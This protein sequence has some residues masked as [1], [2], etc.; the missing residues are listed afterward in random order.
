[1]KETARRE[2]YEETGTIQVAF[3]P[4]C[5]YSVIGENQDERK[6][7]MLYKADVN[8]IGKKPRSEID[9]VIYLDELP[10]DIRM[11]TYPEMMSVFMRE[12]QEK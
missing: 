4:M 6:W 8:V 5:V 7:G 10:K 2:L 1:M 12:F 3:D 11:Y 9:E